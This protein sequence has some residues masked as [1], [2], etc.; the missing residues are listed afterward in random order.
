MN[1]INARMMLA[2]FVVLILGFVGGYA[3]RGVHRDAP[4][5]S[6]AFGLNNNNNSDNPGSIHDFW[7]RMNANKPPSPSPSLSTPQNSNPNSSPDGTFL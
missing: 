3:V 2:L 5:P 6:T 7:N 1:N 4:Q